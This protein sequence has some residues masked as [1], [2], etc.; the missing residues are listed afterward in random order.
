MA[1]ARALQTTNPSAAAALWSSIDREVTN[2]APWVAMKA[3]LSTDFVSRRTGN[4][5]YC[6]LSAWTGYTGACLDQ[7]WVR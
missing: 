2:E 6:W 3:A 4:Y 5:K 1:R 7:L